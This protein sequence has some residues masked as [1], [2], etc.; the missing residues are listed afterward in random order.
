M[1]VSNQTSKVVYDG[2]GS[3]TVFPYT[4]KIFQ[5]EDLEVISQ[6]TS[7]GNETTLTLG[8]DYTVSGAGNEGGG[9]VTLATAL[10]TGKK[11][12]IRRNLALTQENDYVENDPFPAE[13]HEKALDRLTFIS[14]QLKEKIDRTILQDSTKTEPIR[15][16]APVADMVVG[17]KSDASGLENKD[18]E[19]LGAI[20]VD[21][22]NTLSSNSDEKVASQKA[23]KTYVDTKDAQNVKLT[24]NQTIAGVKT[25]SS[26]PVLPA[27]D[28]TADNEATRKKFIVDKFDTSTGHDHD[29]TNSKKIS[30]NQFGSL[31]SKNINTVYQALTDGFVIC[32][33]YGDGSTEQRQD[34]VGYTDNSN[35][36]TTAVA[37]ASMQYATS[38]NIRDN[39]FCMPVK[40]NDY[41][42]VVRTE[43]GSGNYVYLYWIPLGS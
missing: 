3:T 38:V 12:I 40:K 31:E 5:E 30:G 33:L 26:I 14:Q 37:S 28:P 7:T 19:E 20:T 43:G 42:K 11:L 36:P 16:P 15:F 9:N 1:T 25:F 41:W 4:F 17:W 29:G 39:S 8:A 24:G 23:T 13:S 27:S 34:A 2:D 18:V 22:D 6:D 21:T 32:R 10:A 35:P